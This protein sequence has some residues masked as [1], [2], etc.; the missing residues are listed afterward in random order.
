MMPLPDILKP[1]RDG[2]AWLLWLALPLKALSAP[3][4]QTLTWISPATNSVLRL[5]QPYPLNAT[6]SSGLPV[7]FRVVAGPAVIENGN[8]V[9]TNAGRVTLAADQLGTLE[10]QP[11]TTLRRFNR[12]KIE[13]VLVGATGATGGAADVQVVDTLAYVAAET[14]GLQIVDV[15]D[16]SQ[17]KLAGGIDTPGTALEI[18]VV[19]SVAYVADAHGGLAIF[20]VSNPV[21]PALL[22]SH[23]FPGDSISR[24]QVVGAFAYLASSAHGLQI[25]DV[26]NPRQ[27]VLVGELGDP[28]WAVEDFQVVGDLAFLAAGGGGLQVLNVGNPSG[29]LRLGSFAPAYT[30]SVRVAGN[31]AVISDLSAQLRILDVSDGANPTQIGSV[32]YREEGFPFCCYGPRIELTDGFAFLSGN[33]FRLEVADI[34]IPTEPLHLG[35]FFQNE[36][37]ANLQ[38]RGDLTYQAGYSRGLRIMRRSERIPQRLEFT[39]PTL[40]SFGA[41]PTRLTVTASSGLPVDFTVVSGAATLAG[42]ILTAT[43]PGLVVVRAEQPGNQQF[44]PVRTTKTISFVVGGEPVGVVVDHGFQL[45]SRVSV[46]IVS[47]APLPDGGLVIAGAGTVEGQFGN[48]FASSIARLMPDG[49]LDTTFPSWAADVREPYLW[50]PV[51]SVVLQGDRLI[52]VSHQ[53]CVGVGGQFDFGSVSYL[54][55]LLPNASNWRQIPGVSKVVW[56]YP[57]PSGGLLLA[58]GNSQTIPGTAGSGVFLHLSRFTAEGLPDPR[59]VLPAGMAAA[60]GGALSID[61]VRPLAAGGTIVAGAMLWPYNRGSD[62]QPNTDVFRLK[63][64]GQLQ[65]HHTLDSASWLTPA[66]FVA[67]VTGD[68]LVLLPSREVLDAKTGTRRGTFPIPPDVISRTA[69]Y[70]QEPDGRL[71]LSGTFTNYAGVPRR[72]LAAVFPDG[73]LDLSFDPGLGTTNAF[74]AIARQADGALLLAGPAGTFDGIN[75]RGLIRLVQGNP[76]YV[77]PTQ[78]IFHVQA[79]TPLFECGYPGEV[80][81]VR[82]GLTT[83]TNRVRVQTLAETATAGADFVGVDTELVF[84]PGEGVKTVP[85][86]VLRDDLPEETE[87]FWVK[88]Q[89]ESGSTVLGPTNLPVQIGS[90]DCGVS[91]LTN[92]ITMGEGAGYSSVLAFTIPYPPPGFTTRLRTRDV[93]AEAGR[94]YVAWG[95]SAVASPLVPI[96]ISDNPWA[97]GTRQFLV[98]A[99]DTESGE[100]VT[101]GQSL[102]VTISDDD[103]LAGPY[104]GMTGNL[105]GFAAVRDGWLMVGDF[106]TVDGW[107][108]PGLARFTLGGDLDHAFEPPAELAGLVVCA[109]GTPDGGVLLGGNFARLVTWPANGLVRLNA[110][111]QFD[112]AFELRPPLGGTNC[113]ASTNQL[114]AILVEPDGSGFV[115][116]NFPAFFGCDPSPRLLRISPVGQVEASW[117]IP[118]H[119]P[120][121]NFTLTGNGQGRRILQGAVGVF[122]VEATGLTRLDEVDLGVGAPLVVLPDAG[123]AG[124]SGNVLVLHSPD[125]SLLGEVTQFRAEEDVWTGWQLHS[126]AARADGHLLL[127]GVFQSTTRPGFLRVLTLGLDPAAL[128]TGQVAVGEEVSLLRSLAMIAHP[129]GPI[130]ALNTLSYGQA[131]PKWLR[132]D[133]AGRP[134]ADLEFDR[135]VMDGQ[136]QFHLALRGQAPEGYAVEVSD[137]LVNWTEWFKSAEINWGQTFM[138]PPLP[139]ELAGRYFR[140]R[141]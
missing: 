122:A 68:L 134:V 90:V 99:Y 88:T 10:W 119:Q 28:V 94:D 137:N 57:E 49:V 78:P 128:V 93:T 14:S 13:F 54:F 83:Q 1:L 24:V 66:R 73:S 20:D 19:N 65:W 4:P 48:P 89:F 84:L 121:S 140:L 56:P 82:T 112:T 133:A 113:P 109:A 107:P 17:P 12:G 110:A 46:N 120:A 25:V 71:I 47:L 100:T 116:G 64:D 124:L 8:I 31:T 125:G 127:S 111:G 35:H 53:C 59:F 15:S 50:A 16:P 32:A 105:R 75:H 114:K 51:A 139:P 61:Y 141:F 38:V 43:T 91:F 58:G 23:S 129:D 104:R 5:H 60:A 34:S 80:H 117:L 132:L 118:G 126:V 131:E 21:K 95:G 11:A 72:G 96:Q 18:E 7:T 30:R 45:D 92:A 39:P 2:L 106:P 115:A 3:A 98:E 6:A 101:P 36:F 123:L 41:A 85:L 42:D 76:N 67:E 102:T 136:R 44:G 63:P 74:T 69:T 29:L 97:D 52:A 138:T 135:V 37:P 81:V 130:A 70:F 77:P 33:P 108:R 86:T 9:A 22:A 103:T 79:T 40:V 26:S 87:F 55:D 62:Y 27:P